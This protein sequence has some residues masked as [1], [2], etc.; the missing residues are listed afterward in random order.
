M[1]R[2]IVLVVVAEY[3][4]SKSTLSSPPGGSV[5]LMIVLLPLLVSKKVGV[6]ADRLRKD[7]IQLARDRQLVL[8]ELGQAV[9]HDGVLEVRCDHALQ[10]VHVICAKLTQAFVHQAAQVTVSLAAIRLKDPRL[11]HTI[12]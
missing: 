6:G 9:D 11:K 1:L 7:L 5:V 10:Q 2:L 3:E 4:D 8:L 12:K